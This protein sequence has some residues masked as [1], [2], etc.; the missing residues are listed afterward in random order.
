M[1]VRSILRLSLLFCVLTAPVAIRASQTDAMVSVSM[2]SLENP[3]RAIA[4]PNSWKYSP[5]DNPTWS[6]PDF[7]DSGWELISTS[8]TPNDLQFAQWDGI[9]W[10]RLVIDVDS[11]MVGYPLS[12]EVVLQTGASEI[13]LNGD[14]LCSFGQVSNY[15]EHETGY[16]HRRPQIFS[17]K[18]AG[19]NVL[20]VRYSN[21]QAGY[22]HDR[23]I[24]AGFRYLLLDANTHSSNTIL[25][26]RERTI[27]QS[28]FSGILLVFCVVH[29]LL[30]LFYR[31][32][33]EN[34]YYA[35][36]TGSFAILNYLNY[37][38]GFAD[39][40]THIITL[41][42]FQFLIRAFTV[43][44]FIRFTYSLFYDRVPVQFWLFTIV[45]GADAIYRAAYS[46][47]SPAYGFIIMD[48]ILLAFYLEIIRV[49]VLAVIR[50]K[51]GAWIFGIGIAL[52]T[53]CQAV[54]LFINNEII[55][56]TPEI[57]G[58]IGTIGLLLAMSISLSRNFSLTNKR[59]ATKLIEVRELSRR[60]IEQERL[61]QQQLL[62][63]KILELDNRRK[64]KELDEA[65]LLQLS[66]LPVG[67][68]DFSGFDLHFHMSTAT[69]V[70]GDYYDF[71]SNNGTLTVAVGD[72]TGHGLKAG[73]VVAT[74][75]SYFQT[76]AGEVD[77]LELLRKISIG[78]K[79]MNLR[80]LYMSMTL[81]KIEQ[82]QVS[83]TCA[84]MPPVLLYRKKT[85]TIDQVILKGLPLGSKPDF[86]YREM[87]INM[88]EGDTLLV[89][90][91]GL[92]EAFNNQRKMLEL[93]RIEEAFFKSAD[94]EISIIM[95]TL[96]SL[97]S[98]WTGSQ[99]LHD[100]ITIAAIRRKNGFS[101]NI[102]LVNET[103]AAL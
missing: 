32:Q 35:L 91:D 95:D 43:I 100:D 67:K 53:T 75:K 46:L 83:I 42:Q 37:Q 49:V 6:E 81:L 79:N 93:E 26:T 29:L 22:F 44:Y 14:M 96:V 16:I 98:S 39:S 36:F 33:K 101:A 72:A 34:L 23:E 4:L 10:F 82:N 12:I 80:M 11:S 57:Y 68:P 86:P 18:Q 76:F 40:G 103:R 15:P 56:G 20:S 21:H 24:N 7:D 99:S 66:M 48:L 17:F 28:F 52:F 31:Q 64:T 77:N 65:R 3:Y 69:E 61:N 27:Y 73:M 54:I 2:N 30:Y 102:G 87:V 88:E 55:T 60:A 58:M 50:K 47:N 94:Q 92:P 63:R 45:L 25:Q 85:N 71:S 89:F 97:T 62:D 1:I 84:G 78:I 74:A 38:I 70:G 41:Q 9:G 8:I 59:L 5:G 51:E 13:Y 90:S 19:P